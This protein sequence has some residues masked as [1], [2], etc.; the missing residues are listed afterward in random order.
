MASKYSFTSTGATSYDLS[1]QIDWHSNALLEQQAVVQVDGVAQVFG[2]DYTFD[3]N[4]RSIIF[5]NVPAS[6]ALIAVLRSTASEFYAQ[7]SELGAAPASVM[8]SND[9]QLIKRIEELEETGLSSNNLTGGTGT[10]VVFG[11]DPIESI[12][13][14]G[15]LSSVFNA[16]TSNLDIS[17]TIPAQP[18]YSAQSISEITLGANLGN[19]TYSNGVLNLVAEAVTGTGGAVTS[20]NGQGG[21]VVIDLAGLE[22]SEGLIA[23]AQTAAVSSAESYTNTELGNYDTSAEVDAKLTDFRT[24]TQIDDSISSYATAQIQPQIDSKIENI[25]GGAGIT[26]TRF[27][28]TVTIAADGSQAVA[29]TGSMTMWCGAAADC[30]TGWA[31]CDGSSLNGDPA[32]GGDA[33]YAALYNVIGTSFGGNGLTQFNLPNME[34]RFPFGADDGSSST[35][36]GTTGG[37]SS[38]TLAISNMPRHRHDDGDLFAASH[39]HG[40]NLTTETHKHSLAFG[41]CSTSISTER[42]SGNPNNVST[43]RLQRGSLADNVANTVETNVYAGTL[44]GFTATDTGLSVEGD[45]G[46]AAAS[47]SGNTGYSGS[48]EAFSILP[49]FVRIHFII[50]L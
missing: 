22:A 7:T 34:D 8:L 39:T 48:G 45:T 27:Q 29:P 9:E 1:F 50:K 30:P 2:S 21:S 46:S 47:V 25:V 37:A 12:T 32:S 20:V 15:D 6:G 41:T 35:N 5:S 36:R 3:E 33:N 14:G 4:A 16:A 11:S 24:E 10:S 13:V 23:A 49:S 17:A 28:N 31:I 26:A 40:V 18:V 19:S 43:S 38:R 44:A 42:A